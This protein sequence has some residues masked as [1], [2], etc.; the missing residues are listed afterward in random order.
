MSHRENGQRERERVDL[1][2]AKQQKQLGTKYI[3][4]EAMDFLREN[5]FCV[6]LF[7]PSDA[8][9]VYFCCCFALAKRKVRLCECWNFFLS[10]TQVVQLNWEEKV[11]LSLLV[12][13]VSSTL[14]DSCVLFFFGECQC[15]LLGGN[16]TS[17]GTYRTSFAPWPAGR[18]VSFPSP[19][20]SHIDTQTLSMVTIDPMV[21]VACTLDLIEVVSESGERKKKWRRET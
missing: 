9:V 10:S 14:D 6:F 18:A 13:D 11:I 12:A 17:Q 2:I 21:S 15:N 19:C 4:P 7:A 16:F 8:V 3:S 5:G 1:E 20:Y